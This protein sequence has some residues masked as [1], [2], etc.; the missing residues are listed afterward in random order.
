MISTLKPS[1]TGV[2]VQTISTIDDCLKEETL[3]REVFELGKTQR[4]PLTMTRRVDDLTE[5]ARSVNQVNCCRRSSRHNQFRVENDRINFCT[6]TLNLKLYV[7]AKAQTCSECVDFEVTSKLRLR[8]TFQLNG[9][10]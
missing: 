10:Y 5:A 2:E 4:D 7:E 6:V 9:H 8:A 1:A 3:F